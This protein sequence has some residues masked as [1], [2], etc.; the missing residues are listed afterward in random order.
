MRCDLQ[1]NSSYKK[2]NDRFLHPEKEKKP[3]TNAKNISRWTVVNTQISRMSKILFSESKASEWSPYSSY[4]KSK[5]TDQNVTGL[6]GSP[7]SVWF[8][9]RVWGWL[10][11]SLSVLIWHQLSFGP[12]PSRSS[13]WYQDFWELEASSRGEGAS[14]LGKGTGIGPFSSVGN[15]SETIEVKDGK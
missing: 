14:T 8:I 7:T 12:V 6:R 11:W 10:A 5:G 13:W 1:S 3:N 2:R 15:C 4:I 9:I